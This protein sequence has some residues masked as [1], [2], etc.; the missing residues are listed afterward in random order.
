MGPRLGISPEPRSVLPRAAVTWMH[1]IGRG[2]RGSAGREARALTPIVSVVVIVIVLAGVGVATYGVMGGFSSPSA[3]TCQPITSPV[4]GTYANLHDVSLLLPF[5]SVQQGAGVPFTVSLPSG[6][7][8]SKYTVY[9]GDGASLNATSS[10]LSHNYTSPGTYLVEATAVVN[11]LVHDNLETLS[12]LTV[13]PSFTA[14]QIGAL[15]TVSGQILA[16]TSSP[17]VG[18]SPTAVIAAGE[19]VTFSGSYTGEPTNPAFVALPPRLAST[20]GPVTVTSH[21]NATAVGSE[22]FTTPGTYLVTFV[23]SA[24]NGTVGT[25]GNVTGGATLYLNYTWTVFVAA[26]GTHA[27]VAGTLTHFSP[28]PGTIVDYELAPGG[29]LSEDPAIDYETVG[30]E[31]ILNVYQTLISYNGSL[32]GPSPINFVPVL[33][34]C[35]PGSAECASLYNGNTLVSGWNYTFVIQGNTSFYDP[36]THASWGVWPTDVVFSIAR[37]LGFSTL[38]STESNNGWIIAQSLLNG[39]N[40][41]WNSIHATY[42]NTPSNVLGAM[43]INDSSLC[44]AAALQAPNHGCVTF[45]VNG[46]HHDWPYFLELIADPL[47]GSVVP[48]GWFSAPA[49]GAGIPYWTRGNVTGA[50]DHP[51]A[52]P[53]TPGWGLSASKVPVLG[54]DQWEQL[55]SGAF[56]TY[57][58][59][60][61]YN[62]V[63]SGPYYLSQYII[64]QSF[65]L[66]ASP[67]YGQNPDCTWTGCEPPAGQYASGVDVTWETQATQGEQAY[68][69]GVADHATIPPTDFSLLLELIGQGKAIA[70]NAPTLTI[71]FYPFNLQF[72]L[73]GAQKL[74][75]QQVTVPS[76][77]FSYV[78]MREFFAR[79]YPYTTVQT[80]FNTRDGVVLGFN[81]G[82]AIPQFM[83][84]YYPKGIPWPNTDPCTDGSN[85]SCPT[86]WWD[87]MQDKASMYYDPEVA[88]CT[89]SNP[90]EFPLVGET[91]SAAGDQIRQLWASELSQLTSGA[92]QVQPV[93]LNFV[94]VVIGSEYCGPSQCPMPTYALGWAPDYPDPTDYVGPL[95]EANNTYTYGDAVAQT[96]YTAAF[97]AGCGGAGTDYVYFASH[98]V[99]NN[100]QGP[101]YKAMLTATSLASTEQNLTLRAQLYAYAEEIAYRLCLYTYTGQDNAVASMASWVDAS[102]IN[103]NVTI[104]GG[105]DTPFFWLT[106][107]GVQYAGST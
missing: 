91:G 28:H 13:T 107:H 10:L 32:T 35:V 75:T 69:N 97:S 23:G 105:G 3:A 38:P 30:Y 87:Q 11:G 92:V 42:N 56:G 72:N 48:C 57:L 15:P 84:N 76:D 27:G 95:Y 102:S 47:G 33:A 49:Q 12:R 98:D 70:I 94:D 66:A 60:V 89:T 99:G 43:T 90:C 65:S 93:D 88:A 53:G 5:S 74:T 96:L 83:A 104:G 100:C 41:T 45:H 9:F 50:G 46:H 1:E 22:T 54:W 17:T 40:V 82:G 51:C 34:T 26:V 61:Q 101:A 55:G 7:T 19:S 77:W 29:A 36:A 44:P 14:N 4:C 79:A 8:A 6:E 16:N 106:G 64:G 78:G 24:T 20:A 25:D 21:G 63:G 31:P 68:V 73:G 59:H 80:Q 103:T 52:A 81:Y 39:G 85:P 58:G 18:L 67:G 37:T 2:Y 62:M 71:G 86:Y